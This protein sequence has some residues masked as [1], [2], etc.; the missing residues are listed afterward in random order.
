M[1][2]HQVHFHEICYT[3]SG[4]DTKLVESIQRIGCSFPLHVE[5]INGVYRCLDG[6]KRLSALHDLNQLGQLSEKRKMIPVV[7]VNLGD[8]RTTP[9]H[10]MRNTH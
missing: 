7:I 6:H 1:K 2:V 3:K 10:G 5:Y 9:H 4:Y 8:L